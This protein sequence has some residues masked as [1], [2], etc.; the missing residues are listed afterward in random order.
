MAFGDDEEILQDFLLEAGEIIEQLSEQLVELEQS[1]NDKD[2]FKTINQRLNKRLSPQRRR[3]VLRKT[4]Q[5]TIVKALRLATKNSK[6]F[7]TLLTTKGRH[8]RNRQ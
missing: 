2:L 1:P 6:A 3:A 7:S 5:K 8:H 4:V